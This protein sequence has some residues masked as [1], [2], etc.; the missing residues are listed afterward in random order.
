M[1]KTAIATITLILAFVVTGTSVETAQMTR[2]LT[3]EVRPFVKTDAPIVA[4]THVNLIDG[5]GGPA[6]SNQTIVIIAGKI[7]TLGDSSSVKLPDNAKVLDLTGYSVIPG[8]VMMHEHMFYPSS[9][10]LFEQ[11]AL[12]T[13]HSFSFPRLYLACGVTTL[14]TAGS[15]EPYT[16]LNMK[17]LIDAGKMVG[18]KM[19]VTGPYLQGPGNPFMQMHELTSAAEA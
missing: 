8:M 12:Y 10:S 17:R 3:S 5:S 6:K 13:Q 11:S 16:D 15:M 9:N 1:L 19:D 4:L 2:Q 18:P 7:H 14:R